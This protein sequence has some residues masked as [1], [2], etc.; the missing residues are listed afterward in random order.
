MMMEVIIECEAEAFSTEA[1]E[2]VADCG[3]TL[4]CMGDETWEAWLA[5]M[6]ATADDLEFIDVDKVFKFGG[7]E[8]LTSKTMVNIP[9]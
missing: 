8:R 3:A 5:A 4:S 1:G 9:V 2:G 6:C 7:G